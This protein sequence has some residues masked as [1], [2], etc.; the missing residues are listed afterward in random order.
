VRC[1]AQHLSGWLVAPDRITPV[2]GAPIK[3]IATSLFG[4]GRNGLPDLQV[5]RCIVSGSAIYQ[6]HIGMMA[7]FLVRLGT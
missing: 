6:A 7:N 3:Q 2:A 1:S 4:P 5:A